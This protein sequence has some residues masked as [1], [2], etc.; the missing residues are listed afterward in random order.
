MI[1]RRRPFILAMAR[2]LPPSASDLNLL[3]V[4]GVA[5]AVLSTLRQDINAVTASVL[6]QDWDYPDQSMDAVLAYDRD[7][8]SAFLQAAL[9]VLRPGGRLIVVNPFGH[10]AEQWGKRLEEADYVRILVEAAVGSEG[11]LIRGER[12]HETDDTLAR[13]QQVAHRDLNALDLGQYRGA[14]LHLLV[15]QQPDKPVWKLSPD[16]VITWQALAATRDAQRWVL[17]FSSLPKAVSFMQPA[18]LSGR[19]RDVNKVGKFA[20]RE[21]FTWDVQV[22]LNPALE[23][24]A[25]MELNFMPVDPNRAEAPD[26]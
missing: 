3:D 14:Y 15:N 8:S 19:V 12:V 17:A 21:A 24:L 9:R 26:E 22:L 5:Q 25:D 11:L 7:I 4:G 23:D 2:H 6:V 18:I 13:V 10:V 20:R 16:D 1:D